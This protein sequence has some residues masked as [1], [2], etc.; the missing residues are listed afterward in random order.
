MSVISDTSNPAYHSHSLTSSCVKGL[1]GAVV[2]GIVGVVIGRNGKATYQC[3]RVSAYQQMMGTE[4]DHNDRDCPAH[5]PVDRLNAPFVLAEN[6][7]LDT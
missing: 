6:N 7:Y 2:D 5:Q 1:T 4:V 3:D